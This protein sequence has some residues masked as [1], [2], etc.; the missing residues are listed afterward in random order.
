M[1]NSKTL[2]SNPV[3]LGVGYVAKD[4]QAKNNQ[5]VHQQFPVYILNLTNTHGASSMLF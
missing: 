1:R 4:I 2:L 3:N 5:D